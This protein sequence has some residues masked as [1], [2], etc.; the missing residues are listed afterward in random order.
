MFDN[1]TTNQGSAPAA[2]A[3]DIFSGLDQGGGQVQQSMQP[4]TQFSVEEIGQ[5]AS[6][7]AVP[8]NNGG[9]PSSKR[10]MMLGGIVVGLLVLAGSVWFALMNIKT[11]SVADQADQAST[12]SE[13]VGQVADPAATKAATETVAGDATATQSGQ[14]DPL[15]PNP[16]AILPESTVM[17]TATTDS[18]IETPKPASTEPTVAEAIPEAV[19]QAAADNTDSDKDGLLDEEEQLLGTDSS[20]ADT[21]GDGLNDQEEVKTYLSNPKNTDSDKDGFMD[22]DEV[23]NG[24]NPNGAGKLVK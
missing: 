15:S 23:K 3:D 9:E 21:D 20:R 14:I 7:V 5:H 11:G 10:L 13:N 16:A 19:R 24:Y 6:Q 2:G 17:A 4:Q 8:A 1:Q 18:A 12:T 22:G